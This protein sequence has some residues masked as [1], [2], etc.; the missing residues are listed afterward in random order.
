MAK[1]HVKWSSGKELTVE[2]SDCATKEEFI[3]AY[4]GAN[5]DIKAHDTEVLLA[6]EK[7]PEKE[8]VK[9]PV[10]EPEKEPVKPAPKTAAIH[11]K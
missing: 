1:F 5:F 10:K 9:E 2:K 4:F 11:K 8:S 6:G 3:N 7:E